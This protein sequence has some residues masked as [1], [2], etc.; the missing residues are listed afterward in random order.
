MSTTANDL[1]AVVDEAFV[2][3][4]GHLDTAT[5][6]LPTRATVAALAAS[7]AAWQAGRLD[8]PGFDADIDRSRVAFARLAGVDPA[9]VA[10][11]SQVS[12]FAGM[13]AASLPAGARV[14]CAKGDFTSVLFPFLAQEGRGVAVRV[15]PL[16]DICDAIDAR[17]DVVAV[18]SVQSADGRVVD[19]D[20]LAAAADHHG[21]RVFL[22]ATQG[23]GWQGLDGARF[24]WVVAGAYKWLLAPRGTALCAVRPDALEATVPHAAG[25]YAADDPWGACYGAPLRVSAGAKRLDV[26]PAW[27]CWAGAAPALELLAELGVAEIGAYD[28]TLAAR[29]RDGLAVPPPALPSPI[30]VTERTDAAE[31]LAAAGVRAAV[32]AGR[33]RLAC[34]LTTTQ[35]DV[36]RALEALA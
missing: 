19:L 2:R 17:T 4:P 9:D 30:V 29:L 22:D 33:V 31:R 6:G 12:V 35:A 13:V 18:S 16:E 25:W 10:V 1:A 11:G 21:A 24:A 3:V 20:A 32:R 36:D 26:S 15:V 23:C 7:I 14:L 28:L 8:G 5:A 34:H 27:L